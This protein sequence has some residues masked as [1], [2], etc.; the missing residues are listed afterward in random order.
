VVS[1]RENLNK[2]HPILEVHVKKGAVMTNT[3]K[4]ELNEALKQLDVIAKSAAPELEVPNR[5]NEWA[6]D[7]LVSYSKKALTGDKKAIQIMIYQVAA[8]TLE[9]SRDG[10]HSTNASAFD[11]QILNDF[12]KSTQGDK[13]ALQNIKRNQQMALKGNNLEAATHT[14]RIGGYQ[15]AYKLTKNKPTALNEVKRFLMSTTRTVD[16]TT[17][18]GTFTNR[19]AITANFIGDEERILS[20][21]GY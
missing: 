3:A 11:A 10:S 1:P 9:R 12:F 2:N 7:P 21:T 19:N 16:T 18:S 20:E 4:Q 17:T 5:P 13:Q 8:S 6:R 15:L 14:I